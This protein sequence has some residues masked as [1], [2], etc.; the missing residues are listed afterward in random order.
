LYCTPNGSIRYAQQGE[1]IW[2]T[3]LRKQASQPPEVEL[4]VSAQQIE[5][6]CENVRTRVRELLRLQSP[7]EALN[8]RPVTQVARKGYRIEKVE[9]LSEPGVYIPTWV[10]VPNKKRLD[11]IAILYFSEAGKDADGMEFEGEEAGGLKLGVLERLTRNGMQ[12]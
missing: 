6:Y 4:P 3:I 11:S 7:G 10:F 12:W 8:P 5:L 2:S 9:F 1:T